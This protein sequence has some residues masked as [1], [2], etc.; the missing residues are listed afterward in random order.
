MA[1]SHPGPAR[2]SLSY[3]Y[4]KRVSSDAKRLVCSRG[5]RAVLD[6]DHFHTR[7]LLWTHTQVHSSPPRTHMQEGTGRCRGR[8]RHRRHVPPTQDAALGPSPEAPRRRRTPELCARELP[9]V[10]Q[11]HPSPSCPVSRTSRCK[12]AFSMECQALSRALDRV[13]PRKGLCPTH[14]A[15][16]AIPSEELRQEAAQ[17]QSRADERGPPFGFWASKP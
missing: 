9:T 8:S 10:T 5:Q 6:H 4:F 15:S 12:R 3:L 2:S 11:K 7:P 16:A 13:S 14:E 17:E 1:S